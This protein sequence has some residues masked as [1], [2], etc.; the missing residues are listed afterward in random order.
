MVKDRHLEAVL[1]NV[2]VGIVAAALTTKNL[3][4]TDASLTRRGGLTEPSG[5]SPRLADAEVERSIGLVD[6]LEF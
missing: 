6:V 3:A 1:L 2:A 5:F 4:S